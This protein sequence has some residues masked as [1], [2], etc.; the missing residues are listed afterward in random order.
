MSCMGGHF[1]LGVI[2]LWKTTQTLSHDLSKSE[3]LDYCFS[4]GNFLLTAHELAT[5]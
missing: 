3:G 2:S 1:V 5:F 4:A